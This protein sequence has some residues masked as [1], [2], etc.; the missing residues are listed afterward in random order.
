LEV[1][2]MTGKEENNEQF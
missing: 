2:K 1:T